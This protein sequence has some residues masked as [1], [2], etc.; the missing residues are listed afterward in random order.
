MRAARR[1]R[2]HASRGFTLLE[3][4]IAMALFVMLGG[5]VVV[6][7]RQ[8]LDIFYTGTRESAQLDRQDQLLPQVRADLANLALPA[9]F[10][11]PAPMPTD[12]M[13]RQKGA[14][15]PAPPPPVI[16]RL[17][18]GYLKLQQAGD[19][20][21]KDYPCAY[22]ACV[23]ADANEGADR[24]RR[25]AGAVPAKGGNLQDLTPKTVIEGDK[26]TRYNA[27]GGL[28]EILW[29]AVP[30]DAMD[31]PAEGGLVWPAILTLYRGFR[32]PVGHPDKSLLIPEH[33]DSPAEIREACR[34]VAEGLLHFG[35]A[36]RR[37]FATSWQVDT[38]VGLGDAAPY[39][40][41]YWD[42]TRALE[43]EWPLNRGPTSLADPSDDIFPPFVRLEATLAQ[44]T[45]FGAGRGEMTL[46]EGVGAE[47]SVLKVSDAD[48]LMKPNL[49]KSRWI[50]VAGEWM[51]YELRDVDFA[52]R[53]VRVR[54]GMRGTK[55]VP[56]SVGDW[57]YVGAPATLDVRLPVYRDDYVVRRDG[58]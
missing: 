57:A 41:P 40:G 6:F 54:R 3:I 8:S 42:S 53:E 22:I 2:P 33:F 56:H 50:K 12:D 34:P 51:E 10:Q 30:T 48:I 36:W 4:L 27:T 46:R 19:G 24:L 35:A 52:K 55:K 38:G 23:V 32:S 37:V 49:G 18:A 17:R 58:K 11:A 16:V 14:D 43:K 44:P 5:M 47:D 1:S 13:L 9:S 20:A 28:T 29:I 31:P 25:R 21:F 45:Q 26:D 15:R 39:V 7:L